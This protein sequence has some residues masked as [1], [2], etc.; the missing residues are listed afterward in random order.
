MTAFRSAPKVNA[1]PTDGPVGAKLRA[2][3]SPFVLRCLD[4][5][6][7]DRSLPALD[8]PC[9]RGRHS[10]LLSHRGF[11]VVGADIDPLSLSVV[12]APGSRWTIS[13]VIIDARAPLPFRRETFGLAM[14]VHFVEDG[15]IPAVAALVAHGGYLI[16]E[17][18][19]FNG[20]N[21][22]DLPQSGEIRKLV[23]PDFEILSY[24]ERHSP[25]PTIRSVS[26]KLCAKKRAA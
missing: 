23:E 13:P 7:I 21:W 22:R 26:V 11:D 6:A 19:G 1:I 18:F 14:I 12:R 9:G 5:V 16:F 8:M 15:I 4:S 10:R 17:T 20:E 2:E 25:Q 3:A 24:Q